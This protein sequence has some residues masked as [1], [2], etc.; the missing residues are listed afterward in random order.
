MKSSGCKC[1]SVFLFC[2]KK[3]QEEKKENRKRP[4]FI[5]GL[6]LGENQTVNC[7]RK[8]LKIYSKF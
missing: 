6:K 5:I 8:S 7:I 1:M 4:N 2:I 3:K